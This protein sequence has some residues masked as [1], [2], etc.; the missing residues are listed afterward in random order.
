[1]QLAG[2]AA[3]AGA[4]LRQ[5]VEFSHAAS[6]KQDYSTTAVHDPRRGRMTVGDADGG[7][8]E[9]SLYADLASWL[10]PEE[11]ESWLADRKARPAAHVL[12]VH[13]VLLERL[14]LSVYMHRSWRR[15]QDLTNILYRKLHALVHADGCMLWMLVW[16]LSLH[17][18]RL[19][20]LC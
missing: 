8:A 11:L 19:D 1:M 13:P 4:S 17:S 16:W 20:V 18:A 12:C 7:G 10:R 5:L 15:L 2:A 9:E 6:A 14:T 3:A